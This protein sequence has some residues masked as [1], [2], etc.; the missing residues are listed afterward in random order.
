[1]QIRKATIADLPCITGIYALARQYM[2]QTGN[3]TQWTNG[4]PSDELIRE[5][6]AKGGCH[7]YISGNEIAGVFYFKQEE[8]ATYRQIYNGRWLNNE[9]YG[10]VHRLASTGKVKGIAT[11]CLQWCF[12]QHPNIRVDTH[13]DNQ[14]MQAVL[15]KNGF[16]KCGTIYTDNG[17]E[18]IA[19]QKLPDI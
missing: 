17:T 7:V 1:M 9:P 10:V 6:I 18:R 5:D 2:Q 11:Y 14:I 3:P 12:E 16:V 13:Q 15:I 4:Y 19:F 8:D